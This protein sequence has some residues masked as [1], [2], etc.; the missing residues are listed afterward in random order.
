M[1]IND[2]DRVALDIFL[3]VAVGRDQISAH[4]AIFAADPARP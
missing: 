1:Q 4:G 2:K 3:V